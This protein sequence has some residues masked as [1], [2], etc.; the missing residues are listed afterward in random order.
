MFPHSF[1]H[2]WMF[3][4]ITCLRHMLEECICLYVNVELLKSQKRY[5]VASQEQEKDGNVPIQPAVS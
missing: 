2:C 5:L 3:D 1:S 4:I